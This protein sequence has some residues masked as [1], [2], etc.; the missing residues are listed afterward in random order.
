MTTEPRSPS[1]QPAGSGGDDA[2]TGP[3][4]QP[5][6]RARAGNAA[7][8]GLWGI[9]AVLFGIL[10]VFGALAAGIALLLAG[11]APPTN[12]PNPL[13]VA[14]YP[15]IPLVLAITCTFLAARRARSA[16]AGTPLARS[17]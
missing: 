5:T 10:T 11:F 4:A 3:P 8:S 16:A 15:G 12:Q 17:R 6:P 13:I 14:L 7:L 1:R 9:F 2:E